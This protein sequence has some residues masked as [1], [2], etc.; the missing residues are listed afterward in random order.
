[1]RLRSS[2]GGWHLAC[3]TRQDDLVFAALVSVFLL[4]V[5]QFPCPLFYTLT[6]LPPPHPGC[7]V[8]PIKRAPRVLAAA[9]G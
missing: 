9:A 5:S 6:L 2:A 7:G 1:M 3:Q 8:Q 4:V